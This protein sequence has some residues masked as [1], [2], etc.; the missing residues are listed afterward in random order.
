MGFV[1]GAKSLTGNTICTQAM[2]SFVYQAFKLLEYRYVW[3]PEYTV[4]FN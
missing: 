3:L 4:K 1:Q 2:V